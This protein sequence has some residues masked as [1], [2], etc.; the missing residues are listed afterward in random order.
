MNSDL[1]LKDLPKGSLDDY[2]KTATFRWKDLKLIFEDPDM[3]KLK[4]V[5]V[6]KKSKFVYV[7]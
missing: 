2:R 5:T 7:V 6:K 1:V 3:Y 4:V